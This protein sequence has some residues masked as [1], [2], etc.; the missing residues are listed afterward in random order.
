[1]N[2]CFRTIERVLSSELMSLALS[3]SVDKYGYRAAAPSKL[4]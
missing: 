1:M 4:E 3:Y 2:Y